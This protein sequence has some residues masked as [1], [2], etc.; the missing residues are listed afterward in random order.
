MLRI[1]LP[2]VKTSLIVLILLSGGGSDALFSASNHTLQEVEYYLGIWDFANADNAFNKLDEGYR[3]RRIDQH[4]KKKLIVPSTRSITQCYKKVV[5]HL[6]EYQSLNRQ[7]DTLSSSY[8][9]FQASVNGWSEP[10][11]RDSNGKIISYTVAK[12]YRDIQV[13]PFSQDFVKY[14]NELQNY[15]QSKYNTTYQKIKESNTHQA[16]VEK[17]ARLKQQADM[18]R[19]EEERQRAN[20]EKE[21]N[22]KENI[23]KQR[24]QREVEK[25]ER[26]EKRQIEILAYDKAFKRNGFSGFKNNSIPFIMKKVQRDGGLENYVNYV[27]GAT[28]L[29]TTIS[30]SNKKL[31]VLQILDNKV[32]YSYSEFEYNE[33][34]RFEILTDKLSGKLLVNGQSLN[35]NFLVLKGVVSYST[36][37]G[38]SKTV[39]YFEVVTVK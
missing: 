21:K 31:K 25:R 14:I 39:P 33:L 32:L 2:A 30:S 8:A 18:Q 28:S 36:V 3:S 20:L 4:P 24:E 38:A 7:L 11:I 12:T 23:I 35:H 6:K 27:F 29:D 13:L 1:P 37:L 26:E 10:I 34:V 17:N 16:E 9:N 19:K 15:I 22:R 5:E